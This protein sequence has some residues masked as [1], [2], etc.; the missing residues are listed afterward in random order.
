MSTETTPAVDPVE[1]PG[2]MLAWQVTGAGEPADVLRLEEIPVPEPKPGEVLVEVWSAGLNFTDAMLARGTAPDC[3]KAPFTL[4][5]EFC[6]EVVAVGDGVNRGRLGERVVGVASP[7]HGSL[8]RFALARAS[9]VFSAPSQLD[10]AHASVFHIAYQTGWF[11]LYRRANLHVGDTLLVHAAAGGL[12]SAA[13]QLGRA[14][15]ARVIAV[16]GGPDKV[17]VARRLGAHT[18]I[19]RSDQDVVPAVLEATGGHGVDV[20]FDPVGG[21]AFGVTRQVIAAEGRVVVVGFASGQ[22]P[23]VAAGEVQAGNY[24]VLGLAWGRYRTD[25]PDLVARAHDDLCSL[26]AVGALAPLVS[27][28]LAFEDAPDGIA[29]IAAGSTVGRLAVTPA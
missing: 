8:A 21:P 15:G 20:V 24:S 11:G 10:D 13:V 23:S 22:V 12:G 18:V 29:R 25:N 4:G 17:S 16:V 14:A 9:D 19:D 27:D 28:R 26:V 7:M 2:S 6:G 5:Q 3:P 1:I